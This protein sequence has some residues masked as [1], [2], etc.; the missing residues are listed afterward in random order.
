SGGAELQI[1][2]RQTPKTPNITYN[3]TLD[4]REGGAVAPLAPP[5]SAIGSRPDQVLGLNAH[6]DGSAMTFVVHDKEVEGSQFFKDGQWVRIAFP[7]D[8]DAI[9]INLG[10]QGEPSHWMMMQS[11]SI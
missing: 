7:L 8:D 11:L 4:T 9:L 10:Y 3:F 5:I 6:N 1:P 2:R